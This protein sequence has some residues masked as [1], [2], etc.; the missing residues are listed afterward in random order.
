MN[1]VTIG[2]NS[3][4]RVLGEAEQVLETSENGMKKFVRGEFSRENSK[5]A[6]EIVI[7]NLDTSGESTEKNVRDKDKETE[8][9]ASRFKAK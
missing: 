5:C 8:R 2:H 1:P 7:K 4:N 9:I 6:L 3:L